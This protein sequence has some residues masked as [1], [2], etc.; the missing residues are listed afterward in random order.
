M[1]EPLVTYVNIYQSARRFHKST[2]LTPLYPPSSP[3]SMSHPRPPAPRIPT[4]HHQRLGD[5]GSQ[6]LGADRHR[7]LRKYHTDDGRAPTVLQQWRRGD[8]PRLSHAT[9]TSTLETREIVGRMKL[10][11]R[12]GAG[13]F[14][15]CVDASSGRSFLDIHGV[16]AMVSRVEC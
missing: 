5:Q 15:K 13:L 14:T 4:T 1:Y 10:S 11:P 16:D 8:K 3:S 7:A 9:E 12:G 2:L 6:D